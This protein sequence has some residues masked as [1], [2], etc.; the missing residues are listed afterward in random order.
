MRPDPLTAGSERFERVLLATEGRPITEAAIQR[1]IE[2][3]R[4]NHARVRVLSIARVYGV[5]FGLPNPGLLPSKGEFDQQRES[6][7]KAIAR[8]KR[9]GLDA[10][11][12]VIGTRK[13]TKRICEEAYLQECEAIVMGADRDRNRFIGELFWE[14]E[15]Q[16]VR[17]KAKVPVYL[18]VD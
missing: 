10:D 9:K 6:V 12:H 17:R 14:Q 16:R 7:G 8:L 13:A 5:A 3:A 2:L 11:G 15:P 4:G 18:V 1:V